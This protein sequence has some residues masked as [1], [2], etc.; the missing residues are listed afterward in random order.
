MTDSDLTSS[1]AVARLTAEHPEWF[2]DGRGVPVEPSPDATLIGT[3]ESYAA[4]LVVSREAQDLRDPAGPRALV[5]RV[6]H[7]PEE[8][9]RPMAEEFAALLAAPDGIGPRPIHLATA[10]DPRGTGP[11]STPE[12]TAYMVVEHVRGQVRPASAWTDDL[13]AAH[14]RQ[15]ARLH[16]VR[17][18]GHGDVT[19]TDRLQPTLSMTGSGEA[20]WQWW[21]EHHP[22]LASAADVAGLWPRVQRL[23]A[24]T[25]PHFARLEEFALVH[26]DPAVPNILVSGGV[27]RYVDWEWA[28]IGDPARDL[29][30]SG[31]AVW[32][33]P[34]YL[35]L[36]PD[37]LERFVAAYCAA[38]GP[39][40]DPAALTA[41]SRAWL[42]NEVF[43][44][45]L[46][47]RR[48]AA[49]GEGREYAERAA[50]LIARLSAVLE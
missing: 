10:G 46:H 36:G 28:H 32:L 42:V 43:F 31:G 19:A 13:L 1:A 6:P 17:F 3:G 29:A 35:R 39:G 38:A 2:D 27:P 49:R 48:Q 40:A 41:R 7:R 45:A 50:T 12:G 26:G 24:G 8:L 20:N 15:L 44:V 5:V 14:A 22:E 21:T 30:F 47:F 33:D 23:F 37:R 16:A 9:P 11:G 4:W 34:W 25:E 18:G